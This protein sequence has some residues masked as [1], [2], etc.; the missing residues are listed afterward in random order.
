MKL[1]RKL[2][3]RGSFLYGAVLSLSSILL[4]ENAISQEVIPDFYKEPGIYTNRDYVNQSFNE[5]IDPFS[6]A[7]SLQYTDL[8]IPGN[9]GFDLAVV[10]SYNSASVDP[11]NP[12]ETESYAGLGWTI[13]FGRALKSKD[14]VICND[15]NKLSI[16]DNPTLELQD[17]SRQ[18]LTFTGV[19]SPLAITAQRWKADCITGGVAVYSP[20]GTRYDMTQKVNVGSAVK[21]VYAWYTT[22]ITDKNGNYANISYKT[23]YTAELT[24][25]ATNDGRS[26]SFSYL[27]SGTVT[28]RISSISGAGKTY[29]YGYTA[30]TGTTG[31]YQLTSV[32]RPDSTRWSYS[33]NGNVNTTPVGSYLV[34]TVNYPQGGSI[35]YLYQFIYFDTQANPYSR[36]TVV[37]SK[38]TSESGNWTFQYAPGSSTRY[39]VT[40]VNGPS[41]TTVYEHIGPNYTQSG[42][43]WTAGLL[44]SKK[45]G[46]SQTET[47]TWDKQ[48]ISSENFFRPGAFV[49]K[50]D[51]GAT[52]AAVPKSV[53]ISRNGATY[54]TQYSSY[55][56]YGNPGVVTESGPNGG[57][58]TTS[59]TYYINTGK[60]IVKQLKDVSF[61]GSSTTRAFDTSGN[62]SSESIDGVTTSFSYDSQ[63]NISSI[64]YP[65]NL[66]HSFSS[67][68]R[69]IPRTESQP[70]SISITRTVNDAGNITVETNGES[71][72]TR[73]TYDG[74]DR[75]KTIIPPMGNTVSI[76]YTSNTKTATRGDL[77]E[78]T[79]Y[80]GFGSPTRVVLGGIATTYRYD[81]LGRKT[82]E[83]NPDSTSGTS[84][85][86]DDLDRPTRVTNSDSTYVGISYGAATKSV[87]DENG[88]TTRYTYRAYGSP[89]K[90]LLMVVTAP[91][92]SANI[93]VSRNAKGLVTAITQGG[94]SRTFG[95][96]SKYFLTSETNPET[97]TTAYGRDE[98]GNMISRVIGTSGTTSYSYDGQ[99]RLKSVTYPGTTAS[100]TNTYDKTGKLKSVQKSDGI[101]RSYTYNQN[102]SLTS[103]MLN[104]GPTTNYEYNL[105]D[106]LTGI[107][108]PYTKRSVKYTV[109]PLGRPISIENYLSSV[110]YWPSGQIKQINYANGTVTNYGQNSRLWPSSFSTN[111]VSGATY[112]NSSYSYDGVGNLKSISDTTDSSFNRTI[113]YDAINRLVSIAGPWG[114][115]NIAY[116]GYGNITS[117][118]FGSWGINYSYNSKNQLTNTSGSKA[119]SYSYDTYGNIV[120][121]GNASYTYDDA[122][123]LVCYDCNTSNPA[124]YYYDGTGARISSVSTLT[125]H[126]RGEF[127]ASN[128]NLLGYEQIG[129]G[130]SSFAEYIYLGGKRVAELNCSGSI[131]IC[132]SPEVTFYHNDLSGSPLASTNSSGALTWKE[133]YRPYGERLNKSSSTANTNNKLWFTGKEEDRFTGLSLMGA[134]YYDPVIGRFMSVDPKG[135]TPGD[136]HGF[137]RYAYANNNPYKYTDPDGHSPIDVAFLA[138]DLG[139]LGVAMYTGVGVQA[140]A[141]DVAMSVVGV[142]SPI[143]GTGQALKAARTL[144]KAADTARATSNITDASRKADF[145]VDSRGTAV[146]NSAEGA[147]KDLSDGGYIGSAAT[148]T[149]ENGTIHRGVPGVDGPMDIRIMDG[150]ASGKQYRGPRIK[151]TRSGSNNDGVRSDGSRF[152]N[153]EDKTERQKDSHI[154]FN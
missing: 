95:Y 53:T 66:T 49:T 75:I 113:S 139:K 131:G 150:Q 112:V 36:S 78:T 70:E 19:S 85:Q 142:V 111:K 98:A 73:Y 57:T 24:S 146:R 68:Y 102:G 130:P 122:F 120:T 74:L 135:A 11:L 110:S 117:Q 153:N 123:N 54:T 16:V 21:P 71:N 3:Q 28:R 151:F 109:D 56:A 128:G 134:R 86:Y 38:T 72:T 144:D 99:N 81:A 79:T 48:K 104:S 103:E 34:N 119:A 87:T 5:H 118:T 46:N 148:E 132:N 39:D 17:G 149:L 97:G 23:T 7:L 62:L 60:W 59:N 10:R 92:T 44:V 58:R 83:S 136:I 82:F 14:D 22:K 42:T 101:T 147:R 55:D 93:S 143:P 20:S 108:Y 26:I 52:Y 100:V 41:G 154:H 50:V 2:L 69:G 76:N 63:G 106:Q 94:L 91:D 30:I 121:A 140:A 90:E 96:N 114:A 43:V 18:L 51:S 31:K 35:S 40:T 47:Y 89:E 15:V 129:P 88:K 9:G 127:Q 107:Q 77:V 145:I 152:R 125:R 61:S 84:T 4:S 141:A 115:G 13:H 80:N 27:D 33:Y 64:T 65:R 126:P 45:I 8:Q 32:T 133:S 12:Y 37:S 116:D 29:S 138:Y 1:R 124:T 137:N 67:Y 25:V 105:N 6:G